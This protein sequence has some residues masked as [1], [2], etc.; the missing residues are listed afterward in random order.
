MKRRFEEHRDG[1]DEHDAITYRV[2][3]QTLMTRYE[4][5]KERVTKEVE[6]LLPNLDLSGQWSLDIMQN[7]NDFWLID[8][9]LAE[10]SAGYDTAVP[11]EKHRPTAEDWLPKIS[12]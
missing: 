9:A 11:K 7:G 6:K 3:E 1:H 5:N 8:M 2:H 4:Q 10:N 12:V